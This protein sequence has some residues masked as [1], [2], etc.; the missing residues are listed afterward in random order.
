MVPVC[1]LSLKASPCERLLRSL[2]SRTSAAPGLDLSVLDCF[3]DF[4]DDGLHDLETM[5]RSDI[6]IDFIE[7]FLEPIGRVLPLCVNACVG[8]AK[9]SVEQDESESRL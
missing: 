5:A 2:S 9:D 3:L 8:D 7:D 1:S 4:A 6:S